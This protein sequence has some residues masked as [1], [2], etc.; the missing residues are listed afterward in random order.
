MLDS[1]AGAPVLKHGWNPPRQKINT[2]PHLKLALLTLHPRAERSEAE[3]Y[4]KVQ[5]TCL[6]S[7]ADSEALLQTRLM[8]FFSSSGLHSP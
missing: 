3:R 7:G 6:S 8:F 2:L 1:K 4:T 5:V